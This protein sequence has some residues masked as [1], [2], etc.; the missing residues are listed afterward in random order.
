M[1]DKNPGALIS[2]IAEA[3]Q[4]RSSAD[5]S[6]PYWPEVVRGVPNG[7]LRSAIFGAIT[8]GRRPFLQAQHIA[9]VGGVKILFTGPK[10]DQSDLDVWEECLHLARVSGLGVKI[11]FT[12]GSFLR[13]IGRSAGGSDV[14]WLRNAFR[15][16]SASVVEI[17]EGKRAYFGPMIHGGT[18]DEESGQYDITMNPA[19]VTLYGTDGWTRVEW[20]QRRAIKGQPLAQWLHGFYSTHARAY[21]IRVE[22]IHRLC[23]SETAELKHFRADLKDSLGKLQKATGWSWEIDDADLVHVKRAPSASQRKHLSVRDSADRARDSADRHGIA[24]TKGRDS[25]DQETG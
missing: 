21:P 8:R 6:L 7:V 11:H 12:A 3:A 13:S 10:L 15:R 20:S 2:Q 17:T 16:L 14:E 9:S 19:I 1:N 22:T 18:R 23:G 4:A 25:A 5:P 24:P